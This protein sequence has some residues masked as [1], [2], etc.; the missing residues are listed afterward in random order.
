MSFIE[1]LV[2]RDVRTLPRDVED[3]G[4]MV[5]PQ[6]K[7]PTYERLRSL[8]G[9]GER[10]DYGRVMACIGARPTYLEIHSSVAGFPFV[11]PVADPATGLPSSLKTVEINP[12]ADMEA[13]LYDYIEGFRTRGDPAVL[14]D[15]FRFDH[16]PAVKNGLYLGGDFEFYPS[17]ETFGQ[18]TKMGAVSYCSSVERIGYN[19]SYDLFVTFHLE[20]RVNLLREIVG[21]TLRYWIHDGQNHIT[22]ANHRQRPVHGEFIL[23]HKVRGGQLVYGGKANSV[24]VQRGCKFTPWVRFD[25]GGNLMNGVT[26]A[27]LRDKKDNHVYRCDFNNTLKKLVDLMRDIDGHNIVTLGKA[28]YVKWG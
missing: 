24:D 15:L 10:R 9:P 3:Y 20:H 17:P 21:F 8:Q 12:H 25:E 11:L 13:V 28:S 1:D 22:P 4:L 27:H 26:N 14:A 6:G 19:S 23:N 5:I 7:E 16:F 2:T 18:D